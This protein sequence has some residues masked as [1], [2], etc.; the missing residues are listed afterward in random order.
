MPI[1]LL[2]YRTLI[3]ILSKP[4]RCLISDDPFAMVKDIQKVIDSAIPGNA[5]NYI[6]FVADR[7]VVP[8][9]KVCYESRIKF[10]IGSSVIGVIKR[11]LVCDG[12]VDVYLYPSDISDPAI[13]R[14]RLAYTDD[15]LNGNVLDSEVA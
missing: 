3:N 12:F 4:W 6:S 10:I 15:G 8:G 13:E 5:T 14:I 9:D 2:G 1:T 11:I 7:R